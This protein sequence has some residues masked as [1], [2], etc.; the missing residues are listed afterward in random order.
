[1]VSC[2]R[3]QNGVT[4][5]ATFQMVN[6]YTLTLRPVRKGTNEAENELVLDIIGNDIG[7]GSL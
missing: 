4:G 5:S 1:M 7:I 6:L 2:F 3:V